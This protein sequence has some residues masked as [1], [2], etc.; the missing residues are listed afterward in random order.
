MSQ[1]SQ[2]VMAVRS[3]RPFARSFY[4]GAALA[5][6]AISILG[7]APS[8]IDRSARNA[9]P[10]ILIGAH[11]LTLSS[12]LWLLLAQTTLVAKG[13]T[14]L[15]RRLG[16]VG[17]VLAPAIIV[18][19]F[20][21]LRG[22]ALRGYDLSGDL[23]RGL[24]RGGTSL[25]D[26]SGLLFPL[27]ELFTFGV[28]VAFAIGFRNRPEI[29]KRLMI[30][31]VIPLLTEPILHLVGHLAAFWPAIRG[32]GAGVSL[33]LTL[34]LSFGCAINDRVSR[35]RVQP[36]SLWVPLALFAWQILLGAVV[37]R[38]PWWKAAAASIFR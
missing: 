37:L 12:W 7:F 32:T 8:V 11:A 15:H 6:I 25:R 38:S 2:P 9:P 4:V 30:L 36:I 26:P 16:W 29:H 13:R 1:L 34:L 28:M 24:S 14:D 22:F 21:V 19:G 27:S 33:P 23:T 35:G 20:I 3:R 17:L 31:A 18:L 10:T 5:M